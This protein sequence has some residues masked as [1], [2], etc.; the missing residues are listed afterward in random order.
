[1]NKYEYE[2]KRSKRKSISIEISREA[3]IIVRAP[4]RMKKTD[5]EAF[6]HSKS[7][8]IDKHLASMK[9]KLASVPRNLTEEE[10][11]ELKKNAK[12]IITH[13]VEILSEIMGVNYDKLTV[14]LQKTRF[15]S[16]S[17]KK[18]LNFNAVIALMPKDISDYVIVHELAHLKQMNHSA[19]FWKEVEKIIP[20]YK[21]KR[22]WLKE[23]GTKYIQL[24]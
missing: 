15:G 12:I 8:W 23:N 3:K 4:I 19:S 18:N 9:E 20:D 6:L 17:T 2:L 5:I 13:R 11:N 10:K 1:M 21:D 14:K 7:E 22:K 24:I 16:C